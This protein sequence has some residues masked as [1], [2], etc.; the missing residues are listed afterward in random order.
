MNVGQLIRALM[1]YDPRATV[2]I[3]IVTENGEALTQVGSVTEARDHLNRVIVTV[4]NES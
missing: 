4:T 3:H 1:R 2:E